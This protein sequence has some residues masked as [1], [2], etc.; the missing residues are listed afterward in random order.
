MHVFDELDT[1]GSELGP[2]GDLLI[3]G[4]LDGAH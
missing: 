2:Q 4:T 1:I 3:S